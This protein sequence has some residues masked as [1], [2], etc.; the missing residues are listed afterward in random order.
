MVKYN[1]KYTSK[2]NGNTNEYTLTR[3]DPEVLPKQQKQERRDISLY[4]VFRVVRNVLGVY[5]SVYILGTVDKYI[6]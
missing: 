1:L 4:D 2:G 6:R 3:K 5:I